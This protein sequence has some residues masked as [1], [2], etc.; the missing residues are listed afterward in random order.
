MKTHQ[1]WKESINERI[2]FAN[3]FHE[4]I[5]SGAD[6]A[7]NGI[8]RVNFLCSAPGAKT[9]HLVADFNQRH[10]ILMERQKDDGWFIQVWLFHG[11]YRYRFLVDGKPM[12]DPCAANIARDEHDE[13]VS[14][15]EV[16]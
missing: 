12:L 9:V 14:V 11:R 15:V 6:S 10:P 2:Y 16:N 7:N 1:R 3:A 8:K 13:P 5:D 4:K